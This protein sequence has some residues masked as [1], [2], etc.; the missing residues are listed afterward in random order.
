MIEK[1]GTRRPFARTHAPPGEQSTAQ[2]TERATMSAAGPNEILLNDPPT[3]GI[4]SV[5]FAP[6]SDLLLASSW[7]SVSEGGVVSVA[8]FSVTTNGLGRRL[9]GTL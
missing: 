7:D 9:F 4:S 5:C 8:R 6:A 3:D 1:S 2:P